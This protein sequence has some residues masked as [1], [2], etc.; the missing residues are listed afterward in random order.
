MHSCRGKQF[1]CPS[2]IS[3]WWLG[4]SSGLL[5]GVWVLCLTGL[6]EPLLAQDGRQKLRSETVAVIIDAV[7][8]DAQGRALRC[9]TKADFKLSEDRVEQEIAGFEFVGSGPCVNTP[10]AP[11]DQPRVT[12]E[13]HTPPPVTAIVFEELGS[14]ARGAAFRAAQVF[15]RERRL[16]TEFV[17]VF[18]LDFTI[19]AM[20]PYT[21]DE[22]ML[23]DG[24]RR[25]AM[26]PGCPVIVSGTIANA[27]GASLCPG[28]DAG[29]IK[30]KATISGLQDVVRSVATLPGR[31]NV[32][33]FSEGFRVST[34]DSAVNT[35]DALIAL[36][37]QHNVTLHT[38]DALGLRTIDGRQDARRR[39]SSYSAAA[40]NAGGGSTISGESV[41]AL[42]ALDPTSVLEQL[43]AGTGGEF[44]RDTNNLEGAVRDLATNMHDYYQ[45][46]YTPTN[47]ASQ[48][49]YR[50]IA[51]QVAVPG[52]VVRTR[53][54]YY[55]DRSR[56]RSVSS[57]GPAEA[58]PY[59]ILDSGST[60]LDFDVETTLRFAAQEVE[61]SVSVP[62]AGLMF[63]EALGR[64]DA[65][66]TI[67]A[68]VMGA[69][70]QVLAATSETLALSG[71]NAGA[72][73]ARARSLTFKKTLSLKDARAFE[74]IAYDV[75][76]HRA[77]VERHPVNSQGR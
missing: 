46:S 8:N 21:R 2:E 68:R 52:A 61:F 11:N 51:L 57:V 40:G 30:V 70:K 18:A 12:T 34:A 26:R 29:D 37:N 76:G 59:L 69:N 67:L 56:S 5:L 71:P 39:L 31:K 44:V 36:A 4:P 72:S 28:G 19:H 66:V 17:G 3:C 16:P 25:A 60:P 6:L 35:L 22:G 49:A 10:S 45:L 47:Q 41:N 38:I 74:I 55:A 63:T 15:L 27:E 42:L 33:I 7:V 50:R 73:V 20:T 1:G 43:A 48:G 13:V 62:A 77:Y 53:S 23:L 24:V 54:G 32:L 58:A 65:G 64:F 14:D 75:L 9:L